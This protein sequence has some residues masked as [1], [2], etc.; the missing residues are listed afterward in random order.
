[1]L[2]TRVL[3]LAGLLLLSGCAL[4]KKDNRRLLNALDAGIAPE[5]TAAR[6]ALAP[7]VLPLGLLAAAGDQ[8]FVHPATVVDDAWRDTVDVLWT[9]RGETP[10][11]RA[12]LLPLVTIATPPFY[13]GDFLMRSMFPMDSD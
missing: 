1:M 4:V 10:F 7:L 12:L 11:K 2:R 3:L 5:S 9:S 8:L 6:V 13:L